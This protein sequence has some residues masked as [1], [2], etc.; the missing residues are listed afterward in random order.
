VSVSGSEPPPSSL[1]VITGAYTPPEE[2]LG[3][4]RGKEG[5]RDVGAILRLLSPDG[6]A[7]ASITVTVSGGEDSGP[8]GSN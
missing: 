1:R 4:I 5:Y 2:V 6:D 3:P 8:F 7:E